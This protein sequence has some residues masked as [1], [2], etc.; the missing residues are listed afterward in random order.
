MWPFFGLSSVQQM[1]HFSRHSQISKIIYEKMKKS[2]SS[3][4]M[5][6][7]MLLYMI[8]F[9][10]WCGYSVI[11]WY[12]LLVAFRKLPDCTVLNSLS[13]SQLFNP[14]MCSITYYSYWN[15]AHTIHSLN[16]S[17]AQVR[18]AT[19]N[20]NQKCFSQVFAMFIFYFFMVMTFPDSLLF[21]YWTKHCCLEIIKL[22]LWRSA[23][24]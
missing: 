6:G 8:R 15:P 17:E 10:T 2:V 11:Q 9:S 1:C 3:T 14:L 16:I 22:R 18:K 7:L 23:L 19:D 4:F 21:I 12:P 24:L 5:C 20:L 13:S